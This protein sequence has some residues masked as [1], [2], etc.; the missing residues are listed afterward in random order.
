MW[1]RKLLGLN[2]AEDVPEESDAKDQGDSQLGGEVKEELTEEVR[3]EP[4][5]PN[6]TEPSLAA[7]DPEMIAEL[8]DELSPS[9]VEVEN[10]S[11]QVEAEVHISPQTD[12]E[13]IAEKKKKEETLS[14][15]LDEAEDIHTQV[16][17]DVDILPQMENIHTRPEVSILP[18]SDTEV[19]VT[20]SEVNILPHVDTEVVVTQSEVNILPHVDTEVVVRQEVKFYQETV[21]GEEITM[22]MKADGDFS[23]QMDSEVIF[24]QEEKLYQ[25]VVHV[26]EVSTYERSE[27]NILKSEINIYSEMDSE[28]VGEIGE[29][30]YRLSPEEDEMQDMQMK[31]DIHRMAQIDSGGFIAE[32]EDRLSPGQG[33]TDEASVHETMEVDI[34]P[35]MDS[36]VLPEWTSI[37]SLGQVEVEEIYTQVEP[38]DGA[39]EQIDSDGMRDEDGLSHEIVRVDKMPIQVKSEIDLMQQTDSNIFMEQEGVLS[40]GENDIEATSM[41]VTTEVDLS[42]QIDTQVLPEWTNILSLGRGVFDPLP[43]QLVPETICLSTLEALVYLFV[44][45]NL[46]LLSHS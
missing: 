22:Q 26:E 8:N 3:E 45:I 41:S 44:Q 38:E 13:V 15:G 17:S 43:P 16:T 36:E 30:A 10:I 14:P 31:T 11:M 46:L 34:P 40:P 20:Q 29:Q 28:E 19:I 35:Q 12:S 42:A 7:I 4:L 9:D 33:E 6:E 32:Q 27:V 24:Q 25:K 23:P 2:K 5:Q 39:M 1:A 21:V 18:H 37:V